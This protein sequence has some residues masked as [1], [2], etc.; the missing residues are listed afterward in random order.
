MWSSNLHVFLLQKRW[1][2]QYSTIEDDPC[3]QLQ[4]DLSEVQ[5]RMKLFEKHILDHA[6]QILEMNDQMIR[7]REFTLELTNIVQDISSWIVI[8]PVLPPSNS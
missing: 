6:H 1:L 7:E 3:N 4:K 8:H 5:Q 2:N